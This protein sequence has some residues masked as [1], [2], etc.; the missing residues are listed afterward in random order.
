MTTSSLLVSTKSGLAN[1]LQWGAA[2]KHHH[3]KWWLF[4]FLPLVLVLWIFTTVSGTQAV[5]SR[6]VTPGG[7]DAGD[8]TLLPCATVTY[9]IEQALP[10]DTV[11]VTAGTYREHLIIDKPLVLQG[12]GPATTVLEGDLD[13]DGQPDGIVITVNSP[14]VVIQG[15]SIVHGYH[16]ILARTSFSLF[17]S[18]EIHDNWHVAKT[19]GTGIRLWGASEQ[20]AIQAN[21]IYNNGREGIYI[22]SGDVNVQPLNNLIQA[23]II[24]GN[25]RFTESHSSAY[26]GNEQYGIRLLF[27]RGGI[28]AN[29]QIFAHPQGWGL[30]LLRAKGNAISDNEV[31]N[32]WYGVQLTRNSAGNMINNNVVH[33]NDVGVQ[34]DDSSIAETQVNFNQFCRNE[35]FGVVNVGFSKPEPN[36]TDASFNWWGSISGPGLVGPGVGNNV[37]QGVVFVPWNTVPPT[38]GPCHTN[39]LQVQKYHDIDQNGQWDEAEPALDGWEFT[40]YN[41]AGEPLMHSE[42]GQLNGE[43]GWAYFEGLM[44]GDY[45]VCE[46]LQNGWHN[47]DP[48]TEEACKEIAIVDNGREPGS[49]PLFMYVDEPG[50]QAIRFLF[51]GIDILGLAAEAD[52][53]EFPNIDPNI[54]LNYVSEPW[55]CLASQLQEPDLAQIVAEGN[56]LNPITFDRTITRGFEDGLSYKTVESDLLVNPIQ[57]GVKTWAGKLWYSSATVFLECG[58][59]P[60]LTFGNHQL[61]GKITIVQDNPLQDGTDFDFT[62][63]MGDF[64][65]DNGEVDGDAFTNSVTFTDVY[66]GEYGVTEL[67]PFGWRIN[68]ISCQTDDPADTTQH[69]DETAFIDLDPLETIT[70]TFTNAFQPPDIDAGPDVEAAEGDVVNFVGTYLDPRIADPSQNNGIVWDFGDGS[71]AEDTLAPQHIYADDG[72]YPVTLSVTDVT[73]VVY[74]SSLLVTVANMVPTVEAGLNQVVLAGKIVQFN[75][76]VEDPGLLDVLTITWAFGDGAT[77]AD[78]LTPTHEYNQPGEYVVTLTVVDDDGATAVDQLVVLVQ[79][80]QTFLPLITR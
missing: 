56:A 54:L 67:P 18:N 29:N 23:N 1:I 9:A 35:T 80:Y 40:L 38:D 74:Q 10:G 7:T 3:I 64:T 42:T 75:G 62:G 77:A 61:P 28:I 22:G 26:W 47:T 20:N 19:E 69:N 27:A 65:L 8:C 33:D 43:A 11:L 16:G 34:V 48:G 30:H 59:N 15:F 50:S 31:F 5:G 41:A 68:D 51:Q 24:Y 39:V 6:L 12:E 49:G 73:G 17:A 57:V 66:P 60:V 2:K 55:L 63:D 70:C 44:P 46:T 58:S 53:A 13:A 76:Y 78:T 79:Q 72:I 14:Q 45:T 4:A 52:P 32:N 37:S 71:T 36:I 21:L 25:G